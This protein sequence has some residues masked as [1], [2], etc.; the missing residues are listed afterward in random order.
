MN[1]LSER[2]ATS[3]TVEMKARLEEQAASKQRSVASLIR[4]ILQR[5]LDRAATKKTEGKE[6]L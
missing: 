1:E 5:Y 6:E 4:F 2:V 3:T